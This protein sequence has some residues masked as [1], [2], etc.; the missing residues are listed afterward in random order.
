MKLKKEVFDGLCGI[1]NEMTSIRQ[2][3]QEELVKRSDGVSYDGL[4]H[5]NLQMKSNLDKISSY[6]R[7][8]VEVRRLY[9]RC[10]EYDDFGGVGV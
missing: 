9:E 1:I 6:S 5:L 3:A 8:K 10:K 2:K 4:A 7:L